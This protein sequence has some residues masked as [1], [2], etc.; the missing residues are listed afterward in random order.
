[1]DKNTGLYIVLGF[2]LLCILLSLDT[3]D[4]LQLKC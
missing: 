1:M 4:L 2:L 3:H